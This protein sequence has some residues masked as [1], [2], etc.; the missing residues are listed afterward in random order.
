MWNCVGDYLIMTMN[1]ED[2]N[3]GPLMV[4]IG[5]IFGMMTVILLTS[6]LPE[7]TTPYIRGMIGCK[8]D[9][10]KCEKVYQIELLERE[11]EALRQTE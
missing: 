4:L 10:T 3:N 7:G 9:P 8:D 6:V 2:K 1:D 5:F 11:V